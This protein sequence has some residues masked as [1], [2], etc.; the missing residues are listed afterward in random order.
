LPPADVISAELSN[1]ILQVDG[2]FLL[3][4]DDFQVIQDA[5]VLAVV[6]TLVEN[7][8]P[9]LHLVLLTC[10]EPSLPLARLR[11]N[12]QM[13]EIR[14]ADLR[15]SP[16]E[17]AVAAFDTRLTWWWLRPFGYAAPKIARALAQKGGQLI[18][19][20]KG[21]FVTGGKGPLPAGE[22]AHAAAWAATL[23]TKLGAVV[24][25]THTA[26]SQ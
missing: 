5:F 18:A 16:Q 10:E 3:I 20:G 22:T 15:L 17:T 11:A 12:N 21:F 4:L 6:R 23:A 26:F 19:P 1:D 25:E 9:P 24:G 13:T 2:R 14:A 8:P 7:Q